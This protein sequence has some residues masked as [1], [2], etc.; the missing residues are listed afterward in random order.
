MVS[1]TVFFDVDIS[2]MVSF[3]HR[4]S[5][6]IQVLE[7]CEIPPIRVPFSDELGQGAFGKVYKA[8]LKDA[9]EF[10]RSDQL[11]KIKN[12]TKTVAV[13]VLHG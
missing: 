8:E 3:N 1:C 12:K 6:E 7:N 9:F 2:G 10:F 11:A 13:K 5:R 4:A